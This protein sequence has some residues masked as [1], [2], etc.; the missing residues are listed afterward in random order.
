M[1]KQ[2]SLAQTWP[3]GLASSP[4]LL[5]LSCFCFFSFS[6]SLS[7]FQ[8][9]SLSLLLVL[10][11]LLLLVLASPPRLPTFLIANPVNPCLLARLLAC[12]PSEAFVSP[13]LLA[14]LSSSFHRFLSTSRLGILTP[15]I[16]AS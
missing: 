3:S 2:I 16:F 15:G 8:F 5:F 14:S 10:L 11:M 7:R 13:A 9:C 12:Q 6:L 4:S 1:D